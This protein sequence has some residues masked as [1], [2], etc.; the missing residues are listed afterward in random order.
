MVT[1]Y[2]FE[3]DEECSDLNDIGKRLEQASKS[4]DSLI[5]L[6]KVNKCVS[7]A[8]LEMLG[9]PTEPVTVCVTASRGGA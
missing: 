3:D 9:S 1:A 7:D 5:K 6:L 4:K 2:D 8:F